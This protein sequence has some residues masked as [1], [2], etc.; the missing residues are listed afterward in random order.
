MG[1]ACHGWKLLDF[2]LR[3]WNHRMHQLEAGESKTNGAKEM[4]NRH[5]VSGN[6]QPVPCS[7]VLFVDSSVSVNNARFAPRDVAL[8]DMIQCFTTQLSCIELQWWW[9]WRWSHTQ[10]MLSSK[11]SPNT[12]PL[13]VAWII[14]IIFSGR[15]SK[16]TCLAKKKK[17]KYINFINKLISVLC[18]KISPVMTWPEKKK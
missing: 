15:L 17:E 18:W 6:L 8:T 13:F 2:I 7:T 4:D 14:W 11:R 1:H 10:G 16:H 5:G 12:Q 3:G 9:W